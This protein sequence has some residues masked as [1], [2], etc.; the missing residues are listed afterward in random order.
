M[1]LVLTKQSSVTVTNDLLSEM[2]EAIIHVGVGYTDTLASH[3]LAI[4]NH[5]RELDVVE[6][7]SL[8]IF[9]MAGCILPSIEE[10]ELPK[11]QLSPHL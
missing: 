8:R 5:Y 10:N 4:L 2:V 6:L 11:H 3:E 7:Q 1:N 9:E